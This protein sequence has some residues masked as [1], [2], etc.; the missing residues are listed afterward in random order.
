M[1]VF[2]ML[3]FLALLVNAIYVQYVRADALNSRDG[4]RRVIDAQ[5]SRERGPILVDGDPVAA[6]RPVDDRYQFQRRYGQP[7]KYAHLTGYFSYLYGASAVEASQNEILS[8]SDSRLFVDRVVDLVSNTQPQGGSVS[9]TIDPEAQTAA[10]D[11]IRAL[12]PQTEAAVVAIEPATGRL[13]A[14]VSN[15]VYDPNLLASH[16]LDAV[17]KNYQRLIAAPGNPLFNR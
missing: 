5:F 12:G 9:L 2:C 10:Y 3:L 1:A 14:L 8:G 7:F 6:S 11:G 4:N 17:Q 13:L 16:D 15:P